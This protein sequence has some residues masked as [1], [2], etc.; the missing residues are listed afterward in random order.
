MESITQGFYTTLFRSSTPVSNLIIPT[1][2][3]TQRIL[4]AEERVAIQT[5]KAATA[6]RLEHVS[7]NLLRAKHIAFMS[8]REG[9]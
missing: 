3:I 4:P 8:D 7:A 6:P 2:E 1:G 9:P 5:M